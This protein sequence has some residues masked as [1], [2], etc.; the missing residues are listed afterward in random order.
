M[1]TR[2]VPLSWQAKSRYPDNNYFSLNHGN[3]AMHYAVAE[4]EVDKLAALCGSLRLH[5]NIS[6]IA[7]HLLEPI[8]S[9][10]GAEAAAYRQLRLQQSRPRIEN[11][12]SIGVPATVADDY[13]GHFHRLDPFLDQLGLEPV[14]SLAG[15][16]T[17]PPALDNPVNSYPVPAISNPAHTGDRFYRY[18]RDFLYPNGL[19]RHTGFLI[20]DANRRQAWVFN[21]HRPGKAPDFS[22]L[23]LARSRLV[24][25][26]LQGQADG[27]VKPKDN[28]LSVLTA[29]EQD[30][31]MAV[32]QGLANKQVAAT[33]AISPRTVENH[34]RNIYEKLHINTRTQLLSIMHRQDYNPETAIIE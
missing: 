16:G 26:C 29:R 1:G 22:D 31:V 33:L 8:A 24:Q 13:L 18:Y 34:L 4:T 7:E 10:L 5:G 12:T 9:A 20:A 21:F 6:N 2:G 30:V 32:A 23:E 11:L 3:V 15:T 27:P 17:E 28:C 19:V 14:G 25:A